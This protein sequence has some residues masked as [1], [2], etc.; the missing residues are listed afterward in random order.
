MRTC[1]E[2]A[3]EEELE[4]LEKDEE[5]TGV[6]SNSLFSDSSHIGLSE[7]QVCYRCGKVNTVGRKEDTVCGKGTKGMI[8]QINDSPVKPVEQSRNRI[9]KA[10]NRLWS[11]LAPL[12]FYGDFPANTLKI[13]RNTKIRDEERECDLVADQVRV[14]DETGMT[15]VQFLVKDHSRPTVHVTYSYD[16]I[17]EELENGK[18]VTMKTLNKRAESALEKVREMSSDTGEEQ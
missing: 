1:K 18:F 2:C 6:F 7:G 4:Q 12:D 5:E 17:L 11:F 16:Q 9:V 3:T 8:V 13:R 14:D 15:Y 10:R